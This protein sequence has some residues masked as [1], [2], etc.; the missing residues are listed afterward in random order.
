MNATFARATATGDV[1]TTACLLAGLMFTDTAA[2]ATLTIADGNGGDVV[3][4]IS[5]LARANYSAQ[6]PNPIHLPH[7]LHATF[8]TGTSSAT[9]IFV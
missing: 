8:S 3:A 7:G 4:V 9:F 5:V 1:K 2:N 6:F